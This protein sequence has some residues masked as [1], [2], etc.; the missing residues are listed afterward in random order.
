MLLFEII[1]T[2]LAS[3]GFPSIARF[4]E[5]GGDACNLNCETVSLYIAS[6]NLNM[7]ETVCQTA[8]KS[9][10]SAIRLPE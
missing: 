4:G 1:G 3:S 2:K 10:D 5:I 6:F 9:A 7:L 8:P